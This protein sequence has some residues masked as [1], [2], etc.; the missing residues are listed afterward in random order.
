M[1]R[2]LL[3]T[4][5]LS[6]SMF[7][8]GQ[9]PPGKNQVVV[10]IQPDNY[11]GETS[12]S[13]K[14]QNGLLIM[15]GGYIGDTACV[16]TGTC[17]I[18]EIED[19]FGDGICCSFG[20]GFYTVSV[21]GSVQAAGGQFTFSEMSYI[22]CPAGSNC[23]SA[24]T[25]YQDTLN[26][27]IG[28]STWFE[29]VPDTNGTFNVSTCFPS[30]TCDTRIWIYDH[31]SNLV[32]NNANAGTLFYNDSACGIQAFVA[33]GL[34]S[35]KTYYV[36]IGGDTSCIGDTITWQITY[37]GPIVG[38]MDPGACNYNPLATVSNNICIYPGDPNC[39]SGPDLVV[40]GTALTNSLSVGVV[41]GNDVCLI[42]EG[43]LTGYGPRQVINFTTRIANIGDADYYIGQ[44]STGNP[45]FVFDQCHG[46]WHYAGYAQYNIYDSLGVPLEAGFKNGFCVLDLQCFGGTAKY[47][48]G[49]MGI[50]AGCADI[51]GSGLACQWLDITDIPAGRYTL[52]VR[53]NW[54]HDPDALGRQEQRF[55]NN[56]AAVCVRINRDTANVP[57]INILP[58]C[59]PL[60][61]CLG[62]TFGLAVY[63]CMGVCNGSR[64]M[65]DLNIDTLQDDVD[66]DLYLTDIT[67]QNSVL[68]CNDLNDDNIL[69]VTDAALLSGC[70]RSDGGSHS[71]QGGTQN[72][73]RHCEF[74]WSILNINDTVKVGIGAINANSS[75]VDLQIINADCRLLGLDFSMTGLQIDSV[76]SLIA[77][78]DPF[79]RWNQTTGRIVLLDTAELS[80]NKQS[81]PLNFLRVYYSSI[82]ATTV[83]I[84]NI[85]ASVNSDYEET[86][87]NIYNG[88][89]SVTGNSFLYK[90]GIIT[91]VP[92]PSKGIFKLRSTSLQGQDSFLTI[93]DVMGKTVMSEKVVQLNADGLDIDVSYLP[94]G[95]YLVN[96]KSNDIYVIERLVIQ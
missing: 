28:A 18:F 1:I 70:I 23:G 26:Y 93:T 8:R 24:F 69:T 78:F 15:S 62:D 79:I 55:D 74:P 57:T 3:S 85:H 36:R 50:S 43:C 37:A 17:L 80:L 81:V 76:A 21:N 56:V 96:L 52:V 30:N 73:H 59:Q 19:T 5:F 90:S 40:D 10:F 86:Y 53:V 66:I 13:L 25:V 54:D 47:S 14:D 4:L 65:G 71:H 7:A 12:W 95:L 49:N 6:I 39:N 64:V 38:C 92:N 84:S 41:N 88:C 94:A 48:C 2:I 34:Q 33:A 67:A 61:D 29:F 51:Y 83:C 77:G 27:S 9:C 22:N 46:H 42:G 32:W 20:N 63:D 89:V 72:T 75:Y 60:V 11:P 44:P 68:S 87:K 58:N 82:T 35:G 31:C 91:I 16:D 45:Q